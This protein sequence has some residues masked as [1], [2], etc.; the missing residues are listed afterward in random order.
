[1]KSPKEKVQF[2]C[3][4]CL[5]QYTA[6][7]SLK[8]RMNISHDE[9]K[10]YQ[11]YFCS[12]AASS[13]SDLIQHMSKHTKEKPYKCQHCCRSF[14][15]K[16]SVKRHKDGKSCKLKLTYPCYFCGKVFRKYMLL[17]NHMKFIHLMED[18]IR[19][20]PC[21]KHFPSIVINHHIRTVHLFERNQ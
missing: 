16:T 5:K 17:K 1:M 15:R 4:Q 9:V 14:K 10:R 3:P 13:K 19:C 7:H 8:A 12:L 21:Q 2:Q 18:F 11:C 20:N 6:K